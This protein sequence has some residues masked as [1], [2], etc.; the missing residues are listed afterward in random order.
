MITTQLV[1]LDIIHGAGGSPI[2]PVPPIQQ[3]FQGAGQGLSGDDEHHRR[4]SAYW[5]EIEAK[6]AER[7]DA[8]QHTREMEAKAETERVAIHTRMAELRAIKARK[9]VER[10]RIAGELAVLESQQAD[11]EAQLQAAEAQQQVFTLLV[12]QL[13]AELED[14]QRR[15][16][17]ALTV[18]LLSVN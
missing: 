18:L 4:V 3:P 11:I 17:V 7:R 9:K 10:E 16:K 5:D 2:P 14:Y 15:Y 1:A 6:Q 12:D 8:E 13:I